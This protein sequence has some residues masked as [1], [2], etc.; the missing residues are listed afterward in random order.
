M[1]V[2]TDYSAILAILNGNNG[3]RWNGPADL[4][5]PVFVS[6]TFPEIGELPALSSLA[7]SSSGVYSFTDAFRQGFRNAA[8]EFEK[9]TGVRF[10]E[11]DGEA[12]ISAYGVRGS[13]WAGWANYPYAN[14]SY[15]SS[16]DLILDLD[17]T[18]GGAGVSAFGFETFLHEL[19]HAMGLSHPHDGTHTLASYL[20][21][22]ATTV[23]SYNHSAGNRVTLTPMDVEAL[24]HLY[25]TSVDVSGWSYAIRSGVFTLRAGDGDDMVMGIAGRNDLKGAKGAD[26][27][28]GREKAD[29]LNGGAGDDVVA[30]F[31]GADRISGGSGNDR[32][33]GGSANDRDFAANTLKGG[34]GQ[35]TLF[36]GNGGDTL[37]GGAGNDRL[38]ANRGEGKDYNENTLRGGNG[39]DRLTGGEGGDTLVGGRGNDILKGGAGWDVLKGGAGRDQLTGGA[40]RDRD[41]FAFSKADIGDQDVIRDFELGIDRLDFTAIRFDLE[42]VR[43]RAANSG[44]NAVLKVEGIDG[45]SIK[46]IGQDAAEMRAYIDAYSWDVFG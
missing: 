33:F 7:Y 21:N 31:G 2:V 28:I 26:T 14:A 35:D 29:S 24:Q 19:G 5:F 45:F 11:T 13:A 25:G 20:D 39:D 10:V 27:I 37:L 32:L 23:M 38:F 40:N 22:T 18:S 9:V 42:D 17:D 44:A 15:T 8:A 36:G 41:T 4:G 34:P 16:G 6:Y 12:M 1:T 30:G 3:A 46:L 43:I